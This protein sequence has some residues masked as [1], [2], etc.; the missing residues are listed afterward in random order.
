MKEVNSFQPI[1]NK[2]ARILVLGS[3]PGVQSLQAQQ[4]YANPRNQFW[5]II[6]TLFAVPYD[7]N[8]SKRIDFIQNKGIALWDVI[9]KCQRTGSLDSNIQKPAVNDFKKL[10]IYYPELKLI[11]FNGTK[12]F[13]LFKKHVGLEREGMV[14][15]LLPST[16]PA[17]TMSFEDKMEQ[18]QII[19]ERIK[20]ETSDNNKG[21]SC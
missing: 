5:R 16:S 2:E 13:E 18:W 3:M 1:I 4:Y 7:P 9:E 8:Y 20:S 21:K 12:S 6:Y 15:K 17:N 19:K 14:Y 10:F 11:A